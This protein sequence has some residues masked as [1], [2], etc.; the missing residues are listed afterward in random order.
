MIA[1][2]GIGFTAYASG[3]LSEVFSIKKA[4]ASCCS[5]AINNGK[6]TFTE[7]CVPDP[8]GINDC[9]S[10]KGS[11]ITLEEAVD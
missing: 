2:G 5:T 7:R 11:C 4:D 1:L 8:G 10:T 6:C 3:S 9:D